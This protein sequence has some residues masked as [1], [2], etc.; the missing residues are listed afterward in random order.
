MRISVLA[1]GTRVPRWVQ[2]GVEEYQRRMPPELTV[3]WCE[4]A[5]GQRG[6]KAD[7][8]RAVAREGE[9]MRSMLPRGDRVIA[10]E[11]SGQTWTTPELAQHLEGWLLEGCGVSF[12]IGGP[13]GLDPELSAAASLRWSLSALTLPHSL[14]RIVLM[15]Q[16]YRA[17]T[18]HTHHPYHR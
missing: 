8:R 17:W 1:A 7:V 6:R 11:V 13:D 3:A 5:L 4:I 12:L 9:R 18:I 14:V 16:L 2:E 15:E 10:L